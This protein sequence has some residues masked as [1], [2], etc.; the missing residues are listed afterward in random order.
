MSRAFS[1]VAIVFGII[2]IGLT[3]YYSG[4]VRSARWSSWDSY[5]FDSYGGGYS[6][7]NE[8]D[9]L[10]Q[11]M[12]FISAGFFAFFLFT[13]ILYLIKVKTKTMKV[14]SIIGLSI[15]GIMLL[16]DCAMIASPGGMSFDELAPA[17]LL[18]SLIAIAFAIIGTIHSFRKKA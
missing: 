8:D 13:Y 5:S 2:L 12:G 11:E 14:F 15:T 1:I 9:N 4:E 7:S 16:W 18:Y 6:D 17:W 3:V 10:T